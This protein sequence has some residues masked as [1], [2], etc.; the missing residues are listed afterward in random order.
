MKNYQKKYENV[1]TSDRCLKKCDIEKVGTDI[2]WDAKEYVKI[3]KKELK[4]FQLDIFDHLVKT[5]W[6][7]KRFCYDGKKR[8]NLSRNGNYLDGAFG[9][10]VRNHVDMES[11]LITRDEMYSK[12]RSYFDDFFPE[13]EVR[14]PFVDDFKY[15]YKYMTI[16]CLVVVY[17][18]EERL[19]LLKYGEDHKMRY[20]DFIDYVLNYINC[21]NE[22]KG[23]E[24]YIWIFSRKCIPYVGSPGIAPPFVR[25]RNSRKI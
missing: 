1:F 5:I 25:K 3:F 15:P 21:L 23:F 18:M 7:M 4:S 11:R 24:Y 19:E 10:F 13:F 20:L 14:N 9:V 8:E 2:D 6:L 22:D 16:E 17:Q 12:I